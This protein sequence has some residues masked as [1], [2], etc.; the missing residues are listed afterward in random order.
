MGAPRRCPRTGGLGQGQHLFW[1]RILRSKIRNPVAA[2]KRGRAKILRQRRICWKLLE[3]SFADLP[4]ELAGA[5]GPAQQQAVCG[6][7]SAPSEA[8]NANFTNW[9]RDL[10]SNQELMA[11][12]ATVLPLD[13]PAIKLYNFL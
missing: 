3:N 8:G 12:K 11:P 9:L 4:A 13:D 2:E 6:V 5:R 7:N 10:D 1:R